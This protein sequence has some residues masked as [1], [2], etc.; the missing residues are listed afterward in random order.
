MNHERALLLA[1]ALESDRYEQGYGSLENHREGVSRLCCLGVA[2]RVAQ[3][4]GVEMTEEVD[5]SNDVVFDGHDTDLPAKVQDW[6]GFR[7]NDGTLSGSEVDGY[8]SLMTIN[9]SGRYDFR[10]IAGI[11]RDNWEVL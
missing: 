2:C 1:E 3:A 4:G 11:I 7:S 8:D 6:F 5:S 10:A 9:D